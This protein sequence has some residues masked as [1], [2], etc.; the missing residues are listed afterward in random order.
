MQNRRN[1]Q[2]TWSSAYPGDRDA[3]RQVGEKRKCL[4]YILG[5]LQL[6]H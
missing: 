4:C 6:Y 1:Q 2:E 3:D 5:K